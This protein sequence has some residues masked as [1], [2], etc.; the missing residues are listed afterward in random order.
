MFNKNDTI[1]S[2][3]LSIIA[4]DVASRGESWIA[5]LGYA[6]SNDYAQSVV[7]RVAVT[8]NGVQHIRFETVARYVR[9]EKAQIKAKLKAQNETS[10]VAQ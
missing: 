8:T 5:S 7:Y 9:T 4:T 1:Q 3:V 6:A 10:A 2:R